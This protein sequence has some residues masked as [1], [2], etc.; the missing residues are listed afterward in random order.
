MDILTDDVGTKISDLPTDRLTYM[1]ELPLGDPQW[2]GC[3][4]SVLELTAAIQAEL[5]KRVS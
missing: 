1:L 5:E 3:P 4:F 2:E